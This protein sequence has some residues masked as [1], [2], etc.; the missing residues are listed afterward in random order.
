[1][2]GDTETIWR[3]CKSSLANNDHSFEHFLIV[4][5]THAPFSF[6]LLEMAFFNPETS[7]PN[8]FMADGSDD[9]DQHAPH[10]PFCFC[11]RHRAHKMEQI[12]QLYP[13]DNHRKLAALQKCFLEDLPIELREAREELFEITKRQILYGM[14]Y[15]ETMRATSDYVQYKSWAKTQPFYQLIVTI[16]QNLRNPQHKFLDAQHFTVGKFSEAYS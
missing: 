11:I 9:D 12:N 7:A 8:M 10:S 16:S 3:R 14:L 13:Q 1:M 4:E 5:N 6:L 15:Y 2:A